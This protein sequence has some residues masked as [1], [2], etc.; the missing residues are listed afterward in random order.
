M[1]AIPGKVTHNT[2]PT[3][4][5]MVQSLEEDSFGIVM[6][7][8]DHDVKAMKVYSNKVWVPKCGVNVLG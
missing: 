1:P 8:I 6:A 4:L 5:A 2:T 7:S 3:T